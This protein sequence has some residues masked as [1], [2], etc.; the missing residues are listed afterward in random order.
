MSYKKSVN[1]ILKEERIKKGISI[2]TLAKL[3][4]VTHTTICDI[5]SGSNTNYSFNT[6]VRIARVL[7]TDLNYL[8]NHIKDN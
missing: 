4:K 6:I 1:E 2:R 8:G 7:N 3:S 5:E